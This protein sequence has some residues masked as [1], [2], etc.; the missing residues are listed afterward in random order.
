MKNLLK[1]ELSEKKLNFLHESILPAFSEEH[2]EKLKLSGA[3]ESE[4]NEYRR[5]KLIPI[6]LLKLAEWNYKEDDEATDKKLSKNIKN[7]GQTENINVWLDQTD[8]YFEVGNGNHRVSLWKKDKSI[9]RE[10][11]LCCVH[12]CSHR[13]FKRRCLEQNETKF[14][15]DLHKMGVLV[16]DLVEEYSLEDLS[17]TVPI[18]EATFNEYL[19]FG[20]SFDWD[21]FEDDISDEGKEDETKTSTLNL[22]QDNPNLHKKKL[23]LHLSYD[24]YETWSRVFELLH[25]FREYENNDELFNDVLKIVK[26]LKNAEIRK[27]ILDPDN[28]DLDDDFDDLEIED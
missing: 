2:L 14:R 27:V 9:R 5:F 15:I 7:Q 17:S 8:R 26:S 12:A 23:E 18:G 1:T 21:Q 25:S 10:V 22:E 19:E 20:R 13:E 16:N 3:E 6:D 28:I 24:T 4:L 11:V